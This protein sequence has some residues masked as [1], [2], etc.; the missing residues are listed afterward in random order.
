[1]PN[2][3]KDQYVTSCDKSPEYGSD[4]CSDCVVVNPGKLYPY[5]YLGSVG[6]ARDLVEILYGKTTDRAG[7]PRVQ[8]PI[9]V[10]NLVRTGDERMVALLHDVL[11][12]GLCCSSVLL[13]VGFSKHVVDAVLVL[14]RGSSVSYE[15]YIESIYSETIYNNNIG[16]TSIARTVKIADLV[17]NLL[18]ADTLDIGNTEKYKTAIRTLG[19][20]NHVH[21]GVL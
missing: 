21:D 12:D 13:E 20:G 9:G 17:H 14:S 10:H 8:H 6:H 16:R 1:M 15:N 7:V 4:A 18:R 19:R 3:P 2:C 5:W 11:E